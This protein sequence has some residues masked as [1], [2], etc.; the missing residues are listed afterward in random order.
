MRLINI[1]ACILDK[2][3]QCK[4]I[5]IEGYII[6]LA[7]TI[8]N[9]GIAMSMSLL[10]DTWGDTRF[11]MLSFVILEDMEAGAVLTQ[12]RSN[13]YMYIYIYINIYDAFVRLVVRFI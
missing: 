7:Y 11:R 1:A 12:I 3:N 4:F 6:S 13:I 10:L 8:Y 2:S 5:W 9:T